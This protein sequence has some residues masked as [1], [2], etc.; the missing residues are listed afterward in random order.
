MYVSEGCFSLDLID[1]Q[2]FI[3]ALQRH[4]A[5]VQAMALDEDEVPEIADETLP[6]AEGMARYCG[7]ETIFFCC[8]FVVLSFPSPFH[9]F[10]N[11]FSFVHISVCGLQTR[12]C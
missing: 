11:S 5:M 10:V 4:Y 6:D 2:I 7:A 8:V 12:S 1:H 3:I 9:C